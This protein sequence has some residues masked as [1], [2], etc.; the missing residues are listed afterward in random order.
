MH[1]L[2]NREETRRH[3]IVHLI[4]NFM[5]HL[6]KSEADN[7][8]I[9]PSV[10]LIVCWWKEEKLESNLIP[11]SKH[12]CFTIY[13]SPS[14][15]LHSKIALDASLLTTT[16]RH[17][18][19]PFFLFVHANFLRLNLTLTITIVIISILTKWKGNKQKDMCKFFLVNYQNIHSQHQLVFPS[20]RVLH[21]G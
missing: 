9:S 5:S 14:C 3:K 19:F 1:V 17:F 4:I 18:S 11:L 12:D 16:S 2:D 13:F 6:L 10:G 20:S 15:F 7:S 21:Q 8:Y